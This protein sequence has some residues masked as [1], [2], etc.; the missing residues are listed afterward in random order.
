MIELR[1]N[2]KRTCHL[3]AY[4]GVGLLSG[5]GRLLSPNVERNAGYA[6]AIVVLRPNGRAYAGFE[7][8]DAGHCPGHSFARFAGLRVYPPNSTAYLTLRHD[9]DEACLPPGWPLNVTPVRSSLFAA[10]TQVASV[11]RCATEGLIVWSREVSG[12][13]GSF[14]YRLAFFNATHHTCTL[15]GYPGVSAVSLTGHQVGASASRD[16]YITPHVVTLPPEE[17]TTAVVRVT[18]TGVLSSSCRPVLAQGFRVYPPGS[19]LSRVVPV[20]VHVC[21]NPGERHMAV[22]AINTEPPE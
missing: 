12:A 3:Y 22:R 5:A 20:P 6:K 16:G 13:A 2:S 19:K 8:E 11:P 18:D 10:Q 14:Y 4:P 7:F 9:G 21:S 17:E 15:Y 1:N